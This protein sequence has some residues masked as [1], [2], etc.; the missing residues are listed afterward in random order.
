MKFPSHTSQYFS[1]DAFSPPNKAPWQQ[2]TRNMLGSTPNDRTDAS[3]AQRWIGRCLGDPPRLLDATHMARSIH[4]ESTRVNRIRSDPVAPNRSVAQLQQRTLNKDSTKPRPST[5]G[6]NNSSQSSFLCVAAQSARLF[7]S[8]SKHMVIKSEPLRPSSGLVHSSTNTATSWQRYWTSAHAQRRRLPIML[9]ISLHSL[10]VCRKEASE[11]EPM[12]YRPKHGQ[13]AVANVVPVVTRL[14]SAYSRSEDQENRRASGDL[15]NCCSSDRISVSNTLD[16]REFLT[17]EEE[18]EGMDEKLSHDSLN[19]FITSTLIPSTTDMKSLNS[20]GDGHDEYLTDKS[21]LLSP[22]VQFN[23]D[24]QTIDD[25]ADATRQFIQARPRVYTFSAPAVKKNVKLPPPD[26]RTRSKSAG[27]KETRKA[28]ASKRKRQLSGN[29][30]LSSKSYQL[31][32]K[33]QISLASANSKYRCMKWD[34]PYVGIR[35][36]PPTPPC[37][38]AF[39]IDKDESNEHRT[40]LQF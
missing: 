23:G 11:I 26:R 19:E 12:F 8:L 1:S 17:S 9:P 29:Q 27:K 34:E 20:M 39:P 15:S 2:V 31:L 4:P 40:R 33:R 37:T 3:Y 18:D 10:F 28:S 32:S 13:T 21:L 16:E 24:R 6:P 25:G 7:D 14:D 35:R 30:S 38:P 36:D 5:A 22:S